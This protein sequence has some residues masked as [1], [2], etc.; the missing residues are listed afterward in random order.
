ML[1]GRC[2]ITLHATVSPFKDVPFKCE[3]N[4]V[5]FGA[6]IGPADFRDQMHVKS[7]NPL[8]TRCKS[9]A[10]TNSQQHHGTLVDAG[11]GCVVWLGINELV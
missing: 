9:S 5:Q 4:F 3:M 7:E 11:R 1:L 10:L 2:A 6:L 8:V